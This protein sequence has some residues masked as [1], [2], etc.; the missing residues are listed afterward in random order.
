MAEIVFRNLSLKEFLLTSK[1]G[2]QMKTFAKQ[3]H[4]GF[5]ST[6]YF[7]FCLMM[8]RGFVERAPGHHTRKV[9]DL[10]V[11]PRPAPNMPWHVTL[12]ILSS[13]ERKDMVAAVIFTVQ[14]EG[15]RAGGIVVPI[16]KQGFFGSTL[17]NLLFG[18]TL[19][20]STNFIEF[21]SF[22]TI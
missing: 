11:L 2:D 9:N 8:G 15:Q 7:A 22:D 12:P 13:L 10:Q 17:S 20:R 5:D 18:E 14:H 3:A 16:E 19:L 1:A 4:F 6:S 21:K